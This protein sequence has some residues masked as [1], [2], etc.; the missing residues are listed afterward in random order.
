[1]RVSLSL[2]FFATKNSGSSNPDRNRR[3]LLG[4]QRGLLQRRRAEHAFRGAGRKGSPGLCLSSWGMNWPAKIYMSR[5]P[6]PACRGH[7][8]AGPLDRAK[9]LPAGGNRRSL[10]LLRYRRVGGVGPPCSGAMWVTPRNTGPGV[11]CYHTTVLPLGV[12]GGQ[13]SFPLST[14]AP[15]DPGG[16]KLMTGSC[17]HKREP[18]RPSCRLRAFA[19]TSVRGAENEL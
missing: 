3:N 9:P 15:P 2:V 1:M 16:R 13:Q 7:W 18:R 14:C 19:A 5:G 4:R 6:G 8:A 11:L 17:S 12:H 10:A